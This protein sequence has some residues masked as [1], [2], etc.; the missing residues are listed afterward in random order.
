LTAVVALAVAIGHSLAGA[1]PVPQ[2]QPAPRSCHATTYVP[3]FKA[4]VMFGG[5]ETCG[6]NVLDDR[7]VWAWSGTGW[8]VLTE[9]P[10]SREDVLLTYNTVHRRLV[11]IGGRKNGVVFRDTWEWDGR[12]WTQRDKG[13]GECPGALEHAAVAF[14][15]KRNRV[16]VF[17]GAAR[18]A[19]GMRRLT[20]EWDGAKWRQAS[21]LGPPARVAHSMTWAARQGAIVLY[22]GFNDN[23]PLRDFWSW[24]GVVWTELH[25]N[26]PVS[27][28]GPA[29]VDAVDGLTLVAAALDAAAPTRAPVR[30]WRW[31]RDRWS[32]TAA[33][34]PTGTI[35]QGL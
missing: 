13:T 5:S 27:T 32:P 18:T 34:G 12:T 14:D 4:V 33:S 9:F 23:G 25:A 7:R 35:G 22:G 17:G 11:L 3:D 24:N 8:R 30:V 15:A 10:D 26:G 21:A 2:E 29:L 20:C 1:G 19:G 31:Q 6:R 16:V 28:E